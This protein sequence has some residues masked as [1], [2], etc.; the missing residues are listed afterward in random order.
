MMLISSLPSLPKKPNQISEPPQ[1]QPQS[2]Q[3]PPP[4]STTHKHATSHPHRVRV[5]VRVFPTISVCVCVGAM[6]PSPP[7]PTRSPPTIT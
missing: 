6:L 7:S 1:N 4:Q 2:F 3:K 5:C